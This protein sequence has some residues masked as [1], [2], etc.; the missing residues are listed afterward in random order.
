VTTTSDRTYPIPKQQ[1]YN[2]KWIAV[3][4]DSKASSLFSHPA[5]LRRGPPF[6][7]PAAAHRPSRA[8]P[9]SALPA[10]ACVGCTDDLRQLDSIAPAARVLRPGTGSPNFSAIATEAAASVIPYA[11]E[12]AA[13]TVANTG[14][15]NTVTAYPVVGEKYLLRIVNNLQA[16]LVGEW[17][18]NS[19]L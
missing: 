13:N 8:C 18:V 15:A 9:N 7:V 10:A 2:I 6:V 11:R 3:Y 19:L 12:F 1:S 4:S 5:G 16:I 14:R 17:L